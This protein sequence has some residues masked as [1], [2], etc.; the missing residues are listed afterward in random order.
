MMPCSIKSMSCAETT[1]IKVVYLNVICDLGH[2]FTALFF[3]KR[4]NIEIQNDIQM[5]GGH[6]SKFLLI[7]NCLFSIR[8]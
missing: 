1:G 5:H 2:E 6:D 3:L 8:P 7:E 4:S